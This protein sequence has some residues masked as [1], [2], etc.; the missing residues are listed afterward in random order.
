MRFRSQRNVERI[1]GVVA[2]LFL[3]GCGLTADTSAREESISTT[4]VTPT[5]M[6]TTVMTTVTPTT[7]TP[8]TMAPGTTSQPPGSPSSPVQPVIPINGRAALIKNIATADKVVFLTIDDGIVKDPQ[9]MDFLIENRWPA[10]LFLVA[11]ELK[12]DPAYFARIFEVGGTISSHTLSHP[13]LPG[14]NL[15]E[16]TRQIC[17]MAEF[18]RYG[19]GQ[20]GHLMRPP[21][22][23]HDDTTRRATASCGLNAVVLWNASL[24][25][26]NIDLA[27]RT[28]LQPGDIFLTHFRRDLLSNLRALKDRIE[29]EG[30]TIG[31]LE[32][33]LPPAKD[34]R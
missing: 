18:I 23:S 32:D 14:L 3:T 30:F 5:T 11:G 1:S 33:Y 21:Y 25:E 10:T 24:W 22:G 2:A 29:K 31:R 20:V 9:A 16:Q 4:T 17:G 12:K 7:V 6:T 26:G 27:G 34:Q 8:T 15:S 13:K 19:F 28:A